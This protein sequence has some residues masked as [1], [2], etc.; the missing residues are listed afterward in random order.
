M[1]VALSALKI[2][3]Q[4]DTSQVARGVFLFEFAVE[5]KSG[6]GSA[7]GSKTVSGQNFLC[8]CIPGLVLSHRFKKIVLPQRDVDMFFGAALH[9]HHI[10]QMLRVPHMLRTDQQLLNEVRSFVDA[11]I[12]KEGTSSSTTLGS[13]HF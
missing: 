4:E 6:G 8:E 11:T 10:K 2:A 9:Q 13:V 5:Q 1:V 7:V 12:G 3:A